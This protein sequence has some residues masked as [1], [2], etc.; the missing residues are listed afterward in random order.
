MRL[1]I[2][3]ISTSFWIFRSEF[4]NHSTVNCGEIFWIKMR[5]NE[6]GVSSQSAVFAVD[7]CINQFGN[8]LRCE[9][10]DESL[11]LKS[12]NYLSNSKLH[13]I[14]VQNLRSILGNFCSLILLLLVLRSLFRCLIFNCYNIS[15]CLKGKLKDETSKKN[16]ETNGRQ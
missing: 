16:R 4:S 5:Q 8:K 3:K 13:V 7:I 14:L 12:L 6:I 11:K 1:S 15:I 10:N 2:V 9:C